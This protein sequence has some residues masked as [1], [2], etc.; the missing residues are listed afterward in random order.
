MAPLPPAVSLS[1]LIPAAQPP[2]HHFVLDNGLNV[3]LKEDPHSPLASIRFCC[4]IGASHDP[5]GHTNLAHLLEHMMFEGSH[6]LAAGQFSRVISRLGGVINAATQDDGTVYEVTLPAARL[7]VAL[8]ILGDTMANASLTSVG[9]DRAVKA[10][11]DERRLKLDNNPEQQAYEHHKRLAHGSSPY[12]APSFGDA[13]DLHYLKPDTVRTWYRTWYHPNN[14]TLVVVGNVDRSRLQGWV[15]RHFGPWNTA[16]LPASPVPVQPAPYQYRQQVITLPELRDGLYI[17]FNVPSLATADSL[18][19][20]AAL[21]VLPELLANGADSTLYASLVRDQQVLTGIEAFYDQMTRGDTLLTLYAYSNAD[22]GTAQQ[23]VEHVRQAIETIRQAPPAAKRLEAIK[24]RLLTAHLIAKDTPQSQAENI[25]SYALSGLK[26]EVHDQ[27]M[28]ALIPLTP[29]D[30]QLAAQRFL[31]D[32]RLAVTHLLPPRET[33]PGEREQPPLT[34]ADLGSSSL[35]VADF[36][37]LESATDVD[38]R[39]LPP[40]NQSVQTWNTANGSRVAFVARQGSALFNLRLRF[41]AG[42]CQDGDTPGLAALTLY[43]LDQGIEALDAQQFA[44]RL[45]SLGASVQLDIS[46][47]HARIDLS[48]HC[49]Q[50]LREASL[51][52]FTA[53]VARPALEAGAYSSIQ[54]RLLRY[55]QRRESSPG[56]RIDVEML[57]RLFPQHAYGHDY[58]G[59]SISVADID[60]EGVRAFHRRAYTAAN[61]D[62]TLVG[63]L[64]QADARHMLDRLTQALPGSPSPLP[65]PPPATPLGE[66]VA[67]HMEQDGSN[68]EVILALPLDVARSDADYTAMVV[69]HEILGA[70][71]E[72]RLIAELRERRNLTYDISSHLR[73][74]KAATFLYIKW[75]IDPAYLDASQA[76]VKQVI[77]CFIDHGPSQDELELAVNQLVGALLRAFSD[78]DALAE[79]LA[80]LGPDV[81]RTDHLA[82]YLQQ[83]AQLTPAAVQAAA[84]R[85]LA[86]EHSVSISVGPST[87]QQALPPLPANG[88]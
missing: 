47:D 2:L 59:T 34:C 45:S 19:T 14:A 82:V 7:E 60:V 48:A 57:G 5:L 23:A 61:L 55:L 73:T 72:S 32:D 75:D 76:L 11:N 38:T 87:E 85:L 77:R 15:E 24:F 67:V 35:A 40:P 71:F 83:L 56:Q 86:I 3:Y 13:V 54:T 37:A 50:T 52:L 4:H 46:H 28:Q 25:A 30:I 62:I 70:G 79:E 33:V 10:V 88:Q 29:E 8:E 49:A 17:S 69:A 42:A 27:V 64:T 22:K 26:P 44:E 39:Q 31:T 53:M 58:S 78:N 63:D 74:Y 6:K 12:G 43:T 68:C 65:P 66:A 41:N 84:R 36:S 20:A 81:A 9:F 51:V 21:L 1:S 16:V 80:D 18:T